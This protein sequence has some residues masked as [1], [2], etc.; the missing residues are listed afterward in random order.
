MYV[1]VTVQAINDNP[2]E[3]VVVPRQVNFVENN[4]S[5]EL[6]SSVNLMDI[7]H[8]DQFNIMALHVCHVHLDTMLVV[9]CYKCRKNS[10][11]TFTETFSRHQKCTY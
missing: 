7:D 8:N 1:T 11:K 9:P 2:P 4:G 5:V 6:L 3:L 10:F